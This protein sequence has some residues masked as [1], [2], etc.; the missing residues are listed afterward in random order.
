MWWHLAQET[1]RDFSPCTEESG[2]CTFTV[3]SESNLLLTISL[4]ES[5]LQGNKRYLSCLGRTE[6]GTGKSSRHMV[7]LLAFLKLCGP[8]NG[9]T[10]AAIRMAP[11]AVPVLANISCPGTGEKQ[12]DPNL[13]FRRSHCKQL[14]SM[15]SWTKALLS[16]PV[17]V[18]RLWYPMA[19]QQW[20][21]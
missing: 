20:W 11:R 14:S 8:E 5:Q 17:T 13:A 3:I 4:A 19:S 1:T 7:A 2:T 15:C 16:M 6:R 12:P 18:S 9:A 21:I 10:W